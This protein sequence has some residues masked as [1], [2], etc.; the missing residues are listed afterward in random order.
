VGRGTLAAA[1]GSGALDADVMMRT[2][3]MY[4]AA[5]RSFESMS[6]E[7]R[8]AVQ[9]Y[10]DG[11]NSYITSDPVLPLEFALLGYTPEPWEPADTLVWM[12][13]ILMPCPTHM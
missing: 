13:V 5:Q 6:P 2:L 11:V 1:V 9:A 7:G 8:A 3:G 10:A 12:K 4:P